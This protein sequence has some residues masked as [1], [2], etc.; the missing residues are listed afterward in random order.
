MDVKEA[1]NDAVGDAPP[2]LAAT[3]TKI[4]LVTV[5]VLIG[6]AGGEG[7]AEAVTDCVTVAVLTTVVVDIDTET[8]TEGDNDCEAGKDVVPELDCDEPEDPVEGVDAEGAGAGAGEA[9]LN[10]TGVGT[11]VEL[12]PGGGMPLG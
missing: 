1:E 6:P 4:R 9:A 2:S 11:T 10:G 3:V 5:L 12:G 8:D 7:V